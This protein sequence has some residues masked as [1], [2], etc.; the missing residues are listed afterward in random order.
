M[1]DNVPDID[2]AAMRYKKEDYSFI[3]GYM[4]ARDKYLLTLEK[5]D[6]MLDSKTMGD[7]IRVLQDLNYA[8][9]TENIVAS[10]FEPLLS[11]ELK[12]TYSLILPY[13]PDRSYFEIFLYPSDYH[14]VKT[15][16]KAE[17]LGLRTNKFLMETGSVPT[18]ELAAIVNGRRYEDM[19]EEMARGV[20]EALEEYSV[21]HDPQTIDLVLDKACY[22]DMS[23]LAAGLDSD[24]IK[25]YLTLKIDIIN[26]IAFIRVKE[27]EKQRGFFS[28]VFI[29]N[30]SIQEDVFE[31]GF[32]EPITLFA[33]RLESDR[34]RNAL[35]ESVKMI[36]ETGRVTALEKL[37]DN[38]LL[39]YI[40]EA[41]YITYG[42]E[43]LIAYIA[44]KEHEV[45]TVRIIMAG[46]LAGISPELIRERVRDTYA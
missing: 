32:D 4:A 42:I 13:V 22:R 36:R 8:D 9:E 1:H 28:K 19:R 40:K 27:M 39:E 25:G 46:K 18:G 12:K 5:L 26:L 11:R 33:D 14:N 34:L 7:A 23:S 30:G 41:R 29:E 3:C 21:S 10:E 24:F 20:Q 45:K 43:P 6:R 2:M 31:E 38:L 17:F 35:V 15:L 37:C 44:A 16:L